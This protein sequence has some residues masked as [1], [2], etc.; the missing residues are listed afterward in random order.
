MRS[1]TSQR[2][3]AALANSTNNMPAWQATCAHNGSQHPATTMG[4]SLPFSQVSMQNGQYFKWTEQTFPFFFF[5]LLPTTSWTLVTVTSN[6]MQQ[7]LLLTLTLTLVLR[8]ST[9]SSFEAQINDKLLW[10]TCMAKAMTRDSG[11]RQ[12]GNNAGSQLLT[13]C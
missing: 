6:A 12:R 13:Q 2:A 9:S 4:L 10:A 5:A 1:N 7:H 3:A 11:M 8:C